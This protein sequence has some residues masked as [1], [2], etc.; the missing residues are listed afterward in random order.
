MNW[1]SAN[2]IVDPIII[3][4]IQNFLTST[5]IT[6]TSAVDI[7]LVCSVLLFSEGSVTAAMA[8]SGIAKESIKSE[9][10]MQLAGVVFITGL[11]L[12]VLAV[13]TDIGQFCRTLVYKSVTQVSKN[14][15][16]I[17]RKCQLSLI[18][19]SSS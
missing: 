2:R 7:F 16:L 9:L 5:S 17:V 1:E 19:C 18:Y 10:A 14:C 11:S 15:R 6:S 4:F 12:S 3:F 8:I 13:L